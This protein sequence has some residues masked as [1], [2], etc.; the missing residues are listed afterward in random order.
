MWWIWFRRGKK[1]VFPA[2]SHRSAR[3]VVPLRFTSCFIR[4]RPL[5]LT[6]LAGLLSC[7]P[8]ILS[9][10]LWKIPC[11]S[12]PSSDVTAV[13]LCVS[14]AAVLQWPEEEN[15]QRRGLRQVVQQAVLPGGHW[16]LYGEWLMQM[17][18]CCY[19]LGGLG[20][21]SEQIEFCLPIGWERILFKNLINFIWINTLK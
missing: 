6:F 10:T 15:L 17:H 14:S 1:K 9:V 4:P 7:S 5:W 2:C 3:S 18:Q 8:L 21:R 16:D 13:C 19:H 11:V 12:A 20:A